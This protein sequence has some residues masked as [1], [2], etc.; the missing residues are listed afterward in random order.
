MSGSIESAWPTHP[1][2]RVDAVPCTGTAEVWI[3]DALIALSER[4]LV[5]RETDHVDRLYVPAVDVRWE[6]LES[7]DHHTVCPFKGQADYWSSVGTDPVED[8]V[9]WTYPTPF[10]EVAALEGFIGVYHERARVIVN[11]PWPD[12]SAVPTDFPIWGD[13]TELLRLIDVEPVGPARFVGPQY[14]STPRNVVEGG[15]LLAEAIV[16]ASMTVPGQ[17]VSSASMIFSRAASFDAP[18]DVEVDVVRGGRTFSTVEVRIGQHD[19]LRSVGLLL[20]DSGSPDVIRHSDPMPDVPGPEGAVPFPGFALTGRD[21]RVIDGAYSQDPDRVG[22]PEI[23]VW[24]RFRD[25]PTEP[26]LHTAL[27]AQSMTHWTIAAA[28]LPHAGFGE[29]DAHISLST[30]IMQANV[31]F[32]DDV[33]VTEWLLYTNRAIWVGRGLAQGDGRVFTADGRM[34]ASYSI[35]AMIRGFGRDPAAMGKD[36]SSAM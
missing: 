16:A 4:C 1:D 36:Y 26:Y 23:D 17:R 24:A 35:Q 30:G 9:V 7:T 25:A 33:D 27:Q 14:G 11:D 19:S 29:A 34:A 31:A 10:P 6:L 32:H 5:V 15:L 2:Y 12:G 3:G 28:M 18:V 22:S 20:M 13:A 21:L 8:N